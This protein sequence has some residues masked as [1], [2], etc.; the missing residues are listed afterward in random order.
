MEE[1]REFVGSHGRLITILIGA[2]AVMF[3]ASLIV[4]PVVV[5][6]L[7]PDYFVSARREPGPLREKHRWSVRLLLRLKNVAGGI[8]VLAGIVMLVTPGQGILSIFTGLIMMNYPGKYRLE[9][10]MVSRRVVW[11]S[12]NW[13]RARANVPPLDPIT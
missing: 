7:R 12:F 4:I 2:S 1:L 5:V 11:R 13:L 8:F 10:A 6:G 9:R 3:V